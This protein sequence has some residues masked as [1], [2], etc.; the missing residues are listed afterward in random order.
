MPKGECLN[1]LARHVKEVPANYRGGFLLSGGYYKEG[2][3]LADILASTRDP[4]KAIR[5][6]SQFLLACA[7][8]LD[9]FA[10]LMRGKDIE[11]QASAHIV[12]IFTRDESALKILRK[13]ANDEDSIVS[14]VEYGRCHRDG[15]WEQLLTV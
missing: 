10:K 12:E 15:S 13:L 1:P 3:D 4:A 7:A 9:E 2:D 14:Y 8:R 11:I 5:E 6:W